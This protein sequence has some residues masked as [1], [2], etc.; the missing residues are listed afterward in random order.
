MHSSVL[1]TDL[2]ASRPA[3]QLR[4][5]GESS[6]GGQHGVC[7]AQATR[8]EQLAGTCPAGRTVRRSSK[9]SD[10]SPSGNPKPTRAGLARRIHV[11]ETST[12]RLD[13]NPGHATLISFSGFWAGMLNIISVTG[14]SGGNW[15]LNLGSCASPNWIVSEAGVSVLSC[16]V[17]V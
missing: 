13:R 17:A 8:T 5:S 7:S 1:V 4:L 11:A 10:S 2:P 16:A 6:L 3:K 15:W 14:L 12:S 9:L